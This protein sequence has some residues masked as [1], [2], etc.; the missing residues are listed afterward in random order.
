ME[1]KHID[2]I[3]R[4][5]LRRAK[6]MGLDIKA[7]ASV[8]RVGNAIAES[9]V[10]AKMVDGVT[11]PWLKFS[12]HD[13]GTIG[14]V[15]HDAGYPRGEPVWLIDDVV[16]GGISKMRML[17]QVWTGGWRV[18]GILVFLD[19][20]QGARKDFDWLGIPLVAVTTVRRVIQYGRDDG[21]LSQERYIEI[22]RY[23]DAT[24]K[25]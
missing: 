25:S 9:F 17:E 18:A 24:R 7:I 20:D 2:A 19:Y 8:P 5:M 10:L 22:R 6:N 21:V 23:L 1:Q 13:D 14:P 3:G 4:F 11:L 15:A 16:H 12:K